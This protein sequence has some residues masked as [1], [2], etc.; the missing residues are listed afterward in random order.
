MISQWIFLRHWN[1]RCFF[2]MRSNQLFW[3][4]LCQSWSWSWHSWTRLLCPIII[5]H[6]LYSSQE[7]WLVFQAFTQ[8]PFRSSL[9]F[10][11]QKMAFVNNWTM[12]SARHIAEIGVTL[13]SKTLYH[14]ARSY[15][16]VLRP[17]HQSQKRIF[18]SICCLSSKKETYIDIYWM[19]E[20]H[21]DSREEEFRTL[22]FV[23]Y[24]SSSH[25]LSHCRMSLLHCRKMV[26]E[27]LR[28]YFL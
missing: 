27:T 12:N 5:H 9:Q 11:I 8:A 4:K 19:S 16:S 2:R 10:L 18:P 3:S 1:A 17:S 14:L 22:N 26:L 13:P 25:N 24:P 6:I 15:H 21:H 23:L 20:E 7:L 28:V